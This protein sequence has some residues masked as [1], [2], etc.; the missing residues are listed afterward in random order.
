MWNGE[1]MEAGF[2]LLHKDTCI[3]VRLWII[4]DFFLLF[5]ET[6]KVKSMKHFTGSSGCILI[7]LYLEFPVIA[8]EKATGPIP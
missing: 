1:P 4:S 3:L 5:Y 8:R 6:N 2:S 7:G